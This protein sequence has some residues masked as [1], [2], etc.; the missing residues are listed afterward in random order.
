MDM[1]KSWVEQLITHMVEMITHTCY[2]LWVT[3]VESKWTMA[4]AM[5]REGTQHHHDS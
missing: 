2:S 1:S 3:W 4:L 5:V